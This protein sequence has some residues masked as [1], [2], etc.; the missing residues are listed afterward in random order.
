MGLP[1]Y[2][3]YKL[4]NGIDEGLESDFDSWVENT[5]AFELCEACGYS[6]TQLCNQYRIAYD[7][8][9]EIK[10]CLLDNCRSDLEDYFNDN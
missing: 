2:D 6:L 5:E 8:E 9:E 1:N 7:N 10:D 4:D 3:T